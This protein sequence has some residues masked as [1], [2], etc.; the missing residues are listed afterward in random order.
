MEVQVSYSHGLCLY[1]G[2]WIFNWEKDLEKVVEN[3]KLNCWK[4]N[5]TR[6]TIKHELIRTEKMR[7]S[8]M[9]VEGN[10]EDENVGNLAYQ[11]Y[12]LM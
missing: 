12:S 11:N 9:I 7:K 10:S 3:S 5:Q 2:R 6:K 1:L 8:N 4:L